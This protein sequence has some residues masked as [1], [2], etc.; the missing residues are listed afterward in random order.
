MKL[1]DAV[2]LLY[3]NLPKVVVYNTKDNSPTEEIIH[4]GFGPYIFTLYLDK[5]RAVI[6]E[7]TEGEDGE[8]RLVSNP[9]TQLVTDRFLGKV[10]ADD[11]TMHDAEAAADIAVPAKRKQD[12]H[13]LIISVKYQVQPFYVPGD[14]VLVHPTSRGQDLKPTP[15]L[16]LKE[17]DA[18]ELS[19]MCDD[20]RRS[21]F[22]RSEKLDPA[23]ET[24]PV[25]VPVS[26]RYC[27]PVPPRDC[28]PLSSYV[29]PLMPAPYN[30]IGKPAPTQEAVT[31][32]NYPRP[33][34]RKA[35]E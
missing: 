3:T 12:T 29:T 35:P 30:Y 20:F 13:P 26:P 23:L 8:L 15:R 16:C 17:L 2:I 6:L 4:F 33:N 10:R 22:K 27:E 11:G 31:P 32:L 25:P 24:V 1:I 9:M 7:L 34:P 18:R 19:A 14:V 5:G 21:I 28:E